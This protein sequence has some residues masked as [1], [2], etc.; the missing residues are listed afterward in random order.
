[1][2]IVEI[3][4]LIVSLLFLLFSPLWAAEHDAI[5][6]LQIYLNR[7]LT[8][9]MSVKKLSGMTNEN[10][11]ISENKN[12][13]YVVRIPGFAISSFIDRD[14]EYQNSQ[15]AF[16]Y[17]FNPS[18]L[19]YSDPQKGVQISKYIESFESFKFE[20]LYCPEVIEN[21]ASLLHD[22]HT[23]E[24]IFTN[25]VKTIDRIESLTRVL[26]DHTIKV[27]EIPIDYFTAKSDI[28]KLQPLLSS[29][30]FEKVPSHGDP[31]PGNFMLL[32]GH[33]MLFDWEYSGLN[34]PAWDLAFFVSVMD[35]PY[36]VEKK[37][38][39]LYKGEYSQILHAKLIF[40]KPFVEFWLGLWG[41]FQTGAR[42]DKSE[43]DFFSYFA[44]TR[45]RKSQKYLRSDV[46]KKSLEMI[47]QSTLC[48]FYDKNGRSLF[49][50]I[51]IKFSFK[52]CPP[53]VDF[54]ILLDENGLFFA[55][56]IG[57]DHWICPY[58]GILN[59]SQ[60]A[61]CVGINCPNKEHYQ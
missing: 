59:P 35:Y 1:M 6:A 61:T 39:T 26:F 18:Q 48:N 7:P 49:I 32:D 23:S 4:F 33:L 47:Q 22:I 16:Q 25:E 50:K 44:I 5:S 9:S 60:I 21:I 34:D 40:F 46:M 15:K 43:K 58:C 27:P 42:T 36:E 17:H 8:P 10:Y 53:L 57:F 31:V 20:D 56:M 28:D 38:V 14:S 52:E 29:T 11:L 19:L 3:R 54:P 24:M 2:S 13:Q 37:L 30:V 12:N 51:P 45:F 55:A 41:L